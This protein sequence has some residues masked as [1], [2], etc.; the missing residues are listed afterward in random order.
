LISYVVVHTG[1]ILGLEKCTLPT[2]I[3]CS[4]DN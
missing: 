2:K 4:F 1:S 3:G